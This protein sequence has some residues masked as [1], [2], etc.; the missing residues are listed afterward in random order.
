MLERGSNKQAKSMLYS[1][2][3]KIIDKE[4]DETEDVR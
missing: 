3:Y 2:Y 1:I 4:D